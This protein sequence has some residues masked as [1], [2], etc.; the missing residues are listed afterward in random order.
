MRFG[1]PESWDVTVSFDLRIHYTFSMLPDW[2]YGSEEDSVSV[3]P[4]L[5]GEN[6]RRV[7]CIF[8]E[9][10]I[11]ELMDLLGSRQRIGLS[12]ITDLAF[13]LGTASTSQLCAS[14]GPLEKTLHTLCFGPTGGKGQLC[15]LEGLDV[16]HDS[17]YE[18]LKVLDLSV[19]AESEEHDAS[20]GAYR[21]RGD[22]CVLKTASTGPKANPHYPFDPSC[23]PDSYTID[24]VPSLNLERFV[25]RIQTRS[26]DFRQAADLM[27]HQRHLANALLNIGGPDC[28]YTILF[29][30]DPLFRKSPD[31][32]PL[33]QHIEI[34]VK[35]EIGAIV[36]EVHGSVSRMVKI[37]RGEVE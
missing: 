26:K 14:L 3:H 13:P 30:L 24:T 33:I 19:L 11:W 35:R 31:W 27:P 4:N 23:L 21:L 29:E 28:A 8:P 17:T 7:Q 18:S 1:L 25:L 5:M 32:Q 12:T 22:T 9:E 37:S 2:I 10:S 16:L 36:R 34:G 15:L 20:H 6:V